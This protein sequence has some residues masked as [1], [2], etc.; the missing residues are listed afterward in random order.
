MM[1]IT[2]CQFLSFLYNY[3]E[4]NQMNSRIR[5]IYGVARVARNWYLN[6]INRHLSC[7]HIEDEFANWKFQSNNWNEHHNNVL[8]W[9]SVNAFQL[10]FILDI[11]HNTH[12]M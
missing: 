12:K 3:D 4:A 5:I 2:F 10:T 11:R 9:P 8:I 7:V 6:W 1:I